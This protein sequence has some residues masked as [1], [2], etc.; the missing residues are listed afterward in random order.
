VRH[1][2]ERLAPIAYRWIAVGLGIAI[3]LEY[4]HQPVGQN[5]WQDAWADFGFVV[6]FLADLLIR[7]TGKPGPGPLRTALRVV[8][9]L[10][11]AALFVL[12]FGLTWLTAA[13]LLLVVIGLVA[14]WWQ[15]RSYQPG[16]TQSRDAADAR[17]QAALGERTTAHPR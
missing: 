9:Y 1:H 7:R 14:G 6:L 5:R 16:W 4:I 17:W 2:L 11:L 8:A 15:A 3:I 12:Q 13:M 10:S